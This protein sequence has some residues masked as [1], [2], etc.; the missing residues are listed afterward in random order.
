MGPLAQPIT[1]RRVT[2]EFRLLGPLEAWHDHAVVPLGDQQQRFILVVL[3]LN[4]NK[5]VPPDRI[6]EIVWPEQ[7]ERKALVRGYV[8]KLRKAFDGTGVEI[9]RMATGYVLRV[10]EDRI[11]AVRF[12]RLRTQ[13]ALA[14]QDNEQRLAIDLL[15]RAVSLWRGR[16]LEDIDIDRVGGSEVIPPDEAYLD[17][18][19]DLAELELL[20]GDHRS[21]RDRMRRAI[22]INPDNQKYAELLIRA[23][24]VDGDRVGALKAFDAVSETLA[25]LGLERGTALRKLAER[26]RRGE[27]ASSL[28]SRPGGF[29]GRSNELST[30]EAAAR[31]AAGVDERRAVWIS[32]APGVGKTSLAIEAAHCLRHRFPDGQVMVRLN[33]FTPG[34]TP[35]SLSEALTQLLIE[36]GVPGEQIPSTV[37]RKATLYQSQLHGTKTL[38]VLDNAASPEQI[39]PLLPQAPDCFAVITSRRMG[40]PDISEHIRLAPMPLDDA[41]ALF[42]TLTDPDR[43]RSK[44]EDVARLVKRC[45]FLPVSIT[46]AAA[47]LRKHDRWSLDHLLDLLDDS[48]SL[49]ESAAA[50][51]ASYEQLDDEQQQVFRLFGHLPG[52]DVDILG[53]AALVGLDIALTRLLLHDLHEVCLIEEI[54]PDRYQMLDSVKEF[55]A[56]IVEP[57]ADALTRLLDFYLTTL[58]GAM[59]VAYPFDRSVSPSEDQV[60]SLALRFSEESQALAWITAERDNLKAAIRYAATNGLPEHSWRLSVLIWRHLNAM[61]RAEDCLEGLKL[62]WEAAISSGD[63]HSQA[64]LSLLVAVTLAQQGKLSTSLRIATRSRTLWAELGDTR[65]EA[66]ALSVLA[67]P[68]MEQARNTEAIAHLD[69][70]LAQYEQLDDSR[71]QARA[72]GLLG[73]LNGSQGNLDVARRNFRSALQM[74]HTTGDVRAEA[75]ILNGLGSVQQLLGQLDDALNSH[76]LA[77]RYATEVGDQCAAAYALNDIGNVYLRSGQASEAAHHHE[78]AEKQ[79]TTSFQVRLRTRLH[80]DCGRTALSQG[81]HA[82]AHDHYQAALDLSVAAE[83]RDHEIRAHQGLAKCL[84]ELGRFGHATLHRDAAQAGL[85][86]LGLPEAEQ[87][88]NERAAFTATWGL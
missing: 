87:V 57:S 6:A 88:F 39:R 24:I 18:L 17:A 14:L 27:P 30:I 70:A 76:R 32:G 10:D 54:S 51:R 23:L 66:D 61:G 49:W 45:G 21:A 11:D 86:E 46:V 41:E 37:G 85:A 48:E 3:L 28:P 44:P 4:A 82:E 74:A 72:L 8:N 29:T 59:S 31:A 60:S 43:R 63:D 80:L 15:R 36:L 40:E 7:Q 75:H 68:A 84:R 50:I 71:G 9:E 64:Q 62:A 42:L 33:G 65:G 83:N 22:R 38:V 12:D 69:L 56:V 53:A 78:S 47:M 55:A 2:V 79:L 19:G 73:F 16:F 35:L 67:I 5:P 52:P 77:Y 58:A 13:A 34:V 81:A 1:S 25:D 26:A 20:A